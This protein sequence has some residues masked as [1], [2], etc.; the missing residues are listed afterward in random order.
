[1]TFED[2]F[3]NLLLIL[4]KKIPSNSTYR[5]FLFELFDE[6]LKLIASISP[7]KISIDG[8]ANPTD[9]SSVLK[10]QEQLIS[11]LKK[12]LDLYFNGQPSNAYKTFSQTMEYRTAAY[13][14]ILNICTLNKQENFYRL[15][16]KEDNFPLCSEDM[17]H[18]P[19]EKRGNVATQRYSIPGFPSLYLAKTLYVAWEELNRPSIDSFQAIRLVSQK[20]IKLLDLTANDWGTNNNNNNAYKYLMTWPLIASCAIKVKDSHDQFKPEYILP[21]LLLQWVRNNKEIDGIKYASSHIE[22]QKLKLCGDLYNI[23]LPVHENKEKGHCK[24]LLDFF[25]VT[26][27]ISWQLLQFA[28]GSAVILK[29]QNDPINKRVPDIELIKG[30]KFQYNSSILGDIEKFLDNQPCHK[31]NKAYSTSSDL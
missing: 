3:S 11:G 21:Q 13:K 30:I 29:S 17:F 26:E 8:M 28:Q 14:R 27:A 19:F 23:V 1:M 31:I 18:I 10:K 25:Q 2:V 20:D 4:P 15:R 7:K 24:K 22:T 6:Y 16:I 9:F 12:A 5:S